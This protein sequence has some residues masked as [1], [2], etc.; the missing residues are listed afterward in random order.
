MSES[1]FDQVAS[2]VPVKKYKLLTGQLKIT[3]YGREPGQNSNITKETT[4]SS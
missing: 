4:Y 3:N 1:C 2:I